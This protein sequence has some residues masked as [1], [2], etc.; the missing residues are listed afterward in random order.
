MCGYSQGFHLGLLGGP[1]ESTFSTSGEAGYPSW[2]S[3]FHAGLFVEIPR[4]NLSIQPGLVYANIG[5]N[6]SLPVSDY[7]YLNYRVQ[8]LQIPV[9]ILYNAPVGFG[10]FLLGGGP[11]IG[12][13]LSGKTTQMS[14]MQGVLFSPPQY[15]NITT[16]YTFN[17]YDN[18]DFGINAL[19]GLHFK[20]GLLITLDYQYGLKYKFS[21]PV[22]NGQNSYNVLGVKNNVASISL[23][24]EFF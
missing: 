5:G 12:F 13:G 2:I 11:Y 16:N 3:G 14:E 19:A 22:Q 6:L 15:T 10:K 1:N 20:N 23:G 18:P 8:Y 9:N 24:Y 4:G 17:N 21:Y 7:D